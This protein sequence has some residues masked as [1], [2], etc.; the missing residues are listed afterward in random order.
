MIIEIKDDDQNK[1]DKCAIELARYA[2]S[3]FQTRIE[4]AKYLGITTRSL[5]NWMTK[6][7]EL[8]KFKRVIGN[9]KWRRLNDESLWSKKRKWK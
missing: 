2:L 9:E 7:K 6:H 8:A 5:N 4:V 3:K 1:L